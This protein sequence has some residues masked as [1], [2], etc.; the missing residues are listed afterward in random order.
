MLQRT[1][2]PLEA[3]FTHLVEAQSTIN[4]A[5]FAEVLGDLVQ[6][7]HSLLDLGY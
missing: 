2:S 1:E 4:E 5:L 3:G 6:V 7:Q